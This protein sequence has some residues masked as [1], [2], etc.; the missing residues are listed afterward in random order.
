MCGKTLIDSTIGIYGLGN[1]GSNIAEKLLPF[2]PRKII[3]HNRHKIK[4]LLILNCNFASAFLDC[5]YQYV[6]FDQLL[7]ESDFLI[8]CAKPSPS[9]IRI[10]NENAFSQMKNDSILIN[11]S[12]LIISSATEIYKLFIQRNSS[13]FE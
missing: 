8:I 5:P 7:R 6:H 2:K 3:Y 12:R 10:F 1:I 11:I 13:E 9:N 4:G